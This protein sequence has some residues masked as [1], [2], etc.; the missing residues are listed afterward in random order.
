MKN[1]I[2]LFICLFAFSSL[3][4]QDNFHDTQGKIEIN[5]GGQLQYTLPVELPPAV[6]NVS[7]NV[8]LIYLSN[9]N[10]GIAGYG[11]TV[12]GLTAITRTGKSIERDAEIKGIQLDYSDTYSFNG[13]RLILAQDSPAAYGQD[14]ATYVTEKFSNVKVKSLGAF[15]ANG[16]LAGPAQF[17]VTFEDGSQAWYGAYMG[18]MRSSPTV[19]TPSEYNIVKWKDAQGNYITYSYESSSNQGGFRS[20]LTVVRISSIAW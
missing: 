6:K 3:Y 9:S 12:S 17:E 5:A 10:N 8:S 19:T 14:G 20:D 15:P 2:K 1:F 4:S 16:Q 13:Q 11:W 7:P 18:G